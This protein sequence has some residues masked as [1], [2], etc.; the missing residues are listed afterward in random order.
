MKKLLVFIFLMINSALLQAADFNEGKHY[1]ALAPQSTDSGDKIEVLEF[2]WYGCPHCYSFE[3]YAQAW[4]K[5]KPAN[6]VFTRVP[7]IFRPDWEIQARVYYALS[8]M[9]VIED[10]HVKI[11]DAVHKDKKRLN[12][13]EELTDF[14]VKNG[15]D[16][17][18]F[19][20]EY[21]SFAV[22]GMV[23]KAKKKQKAYKIEGVPSVAVNGKY[24]T[25]GSM[26]GSY[27][28]LVK[29]MDYLIAMESKK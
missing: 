26:S 23:R 21:D 14:V 9:G 7:A 2:F 4:K 13:K 29:I 18:Q 11:F 12:T 17:E 15:V 22:D 28:N 27:D 24:L 16:K 1:K 8:N 19:L 10:V 3:P 5:S 6:V 20:K 25:S